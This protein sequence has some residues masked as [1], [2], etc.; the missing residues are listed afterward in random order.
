LK[1]IDEAEAKLNQADVGVRK[2]AGTIRAPL[3]SLSAL[4]RALLSFEK[5]EYDKASEKLENLVSSLDDSPLLFGDVAHVGYLASIAQQVKPIIE[6]VAKVLIQPK[7][8]GQVREAQTDNTVQRIE[9]LESTAKRGL[10]LVEREQCKRNQN[11]LGEYKNLLAILYT[12]KALCI[13]TAGRH[14]DAMTILRDN[15]P[16]IQESLKQKGPKSELY[17][18][19]TL[20]ANLLT[21]TGRS[22]DAQEIESFVKDIPVE[23]VSKN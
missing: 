1:K 14:P 2:A 9:I 11:L 22:A 18:I 21:Q 15:L 3:T 8:T 5:G 10:T 20:Y 19:F 16:A 17:N 7:S 4:A 12:I 23:N 13:D 6:G